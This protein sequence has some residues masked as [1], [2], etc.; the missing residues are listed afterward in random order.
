MS[1]KLFRGGTPEVVYGVDI[2][3]EEES[4][5]VAF[6]EE[7]NQ[8]L[9]GINFHLSNLES[10]VSAHEY[11]ASHADLRLAERNTVIDDPY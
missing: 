6:T 11:G 2:Q 9:G 1:W 3:G 8:E 7:V 5:C 10:L 4:K